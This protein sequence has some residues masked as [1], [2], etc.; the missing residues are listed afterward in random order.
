MTTEAQTLSKTMESQLAGVNPSMMEKCIQ[1]IKNNYIPGEGIT[2]TSRQRTSYPEVTGYYIP[3]LLSIGEHEKAEA[4]ANWLTTIQKKDGSFGGGGDNASYVFDTGQVIR[5]WASILK[6]KP[7]LEKNLRAACDWVIATADPSTGRLLVPSGSAWSLG[8][9]GAVNEA[10]HIYVLSPMR[11]VGELLNEPKYLQFVNKSLDYYLKNTNITDFTQPNSLSHF[12]SYIQEALMELGCER[13]A[14]LGMASAA[15]FQQPSGAV[16][17]YSNVNWICSTGLAQLA[18]VWYML[19]ET[20]RADAAMSFLEL[21]QNPSGG[22]FGS[23]GVGA[24]YFPSEEISWA[25]KYTI[26]ACQRQISAH[27]DQTVQIY[28]NS[29]DVSDGR[30]QAVINKLG[31]LNGKRVL[32]A[33]CGKGRYSTILK[34]LYPRAEITAMD[35]SSEMLK[36]IPSGINTTQAGIL[37]MP[38]EDNSFDAII[39]IEALEHVVRIDEGIQQLARV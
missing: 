28:D 32:D 17:G 27:F 9:R 35:I 7:E 20:K 36:H 11:R 4:F 12:Y 23:Y 31:D 2:I 13:E 1:W 8:A 21:I 24:E 30:V 15:R 33:G 34:K 22:F 10:I 16:P 14:K 6:V 39:C 26:E 25:A 38:F 19:G 37:A 18:Q 3:T 5:G 29:I